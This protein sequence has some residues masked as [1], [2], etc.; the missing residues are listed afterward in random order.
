MKIEDFFWTSLVVNGYY[1]ILIFD[2]C[3]IFNEACN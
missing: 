2:V 3:F 1:L